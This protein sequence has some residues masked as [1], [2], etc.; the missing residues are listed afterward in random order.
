M[1]AGIVSFTTDWKMFG[2]LT[3]APQT[4][5][6]IFAETLVQAA[7]QGCSVTQSASRLGED[8]E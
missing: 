2:T 7:I 6:L 8:H 1:F 3:P 4:T 5:N